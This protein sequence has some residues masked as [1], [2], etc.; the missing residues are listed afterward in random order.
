MFRAFGHAPRLL[1]LVS[2]LGF[3]LL[4]LG[5]DPKIP[6]PTGPDFTMQGEYAGNVFVEM[7][8]TAIGVQ[9][10]ALGDG[11]FN[12]VGYQG[13]LPGDG[14]DR[15]PRQ[16]GK[17]TLKNDIVE[18]IAQGGYSS[19]IKDGAM[20]IAV[21]G[22][23]IAKLKKQDRVSGTLGAAPPE[24][25]I[26]LFDGSNADKFEGGKMDEDNLLVAGCMTKEK[27]GSGKLHIEFRVPFL[28]KAEGQ[29]R[30][31]SGVYMQGRYE[32]Q[33]LDSFGLEESDTGGGAIYG[34]KQPDQN[35]CYPPL[36]WQTYDI[37]FTAPEYKDGKKVEGSEAMFTVKQNGVVIHRRAKVTQPTAGS[38][39][40]AGPEPGP[41]YLQDHGNPV[42]FQNI[43][44]APKVD[45]KPVAK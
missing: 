21:A 23:E 43:W 31:N 26:V 45:E 10:V 5:A 33:I 15:A 39:V 14:W 41:I 17:G 1:A 11:Q 19:Q 29:A 3:P 24:G 42:R 20:T 12:A 34:V 25:A 22:V 38:K 37:E 32:I 6:E 7:G 8:E 40:A 9:V 30:G 4:V 13:G 16:S 28:P 18:F 35:M 2:V 27:F 44:F 36:A